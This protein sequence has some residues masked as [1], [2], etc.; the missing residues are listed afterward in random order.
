MVAKLKPHS[1]RG[2]RD[3]VIQA[4]TDAAQ[5]RAWKGGFIL[6]R[7]GAEISRGRRD[8]SREGRR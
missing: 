4:D 6:D 5:P 1:S 3:M 8:S 7:E 2:R